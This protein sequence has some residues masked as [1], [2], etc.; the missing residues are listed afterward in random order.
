MA[1]AMTMRLRLWDI[2]DLRTLLLL[3]SLRLLQHWSSRPFIAVRCEG[4][5]ILPELLR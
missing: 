1:I 2:E 3:L 4:L 5:D